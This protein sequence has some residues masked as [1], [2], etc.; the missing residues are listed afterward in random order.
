MNLALALQQL[1]HFHRQVAGLRERIGRGPKQIQAAEGGVRKFE[2]EVAAAKEAHRVAKFSCDQK[3]L[4]LK[5]R[6]SRLADL[7]GRLNQAE[8]NQVYQ[9]IKDQIA[10]DLQANSVLADEILEG[11]EAIDQ[12]QAK[13]G[14]AH[15]HLAKGQEELEKT[16]LRVSEV[17]Q[18]LE[19][20]LS[21]W[22]DKLRAAES[23]LPEEF[24]PDYSRIAKAK[25]EDALAAVESETCS[26]CFQMLTPQNMNELYLGKPIFCKS[27]GR[28]L[29][30]VPEH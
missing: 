10:A 8:S 17:Q 29:Y 3:Q 2:A 21:G 18:Q 26:G 13:I 25:G 23:D 4:Q 9:T 20:E 6:E 1:H 11:L 15:E 16:R 30:L 28:L 19:G 7:R 14:E 5:Q 22:L 27:C 24:L 12:L